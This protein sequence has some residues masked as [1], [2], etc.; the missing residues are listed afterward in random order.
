MSAEADP[1]ALFRQE[2]SELVASIEVGLL[3]LEKR[4]GD[5][6]LIASVFRDLH[7]VKGSGAMFGFTEV[8]AFVHEFETAFDRLRRGEAAV[9][10]DVIAVSLKACDHIRGLLADPAT[11]PAGKPILDA[12][13][14]AMD[15]AAASGAG[16][17]VQVRLPADAI[18]L[19]HHPRRLL[20]ELA[21][22]GKTRIA[23]LPEAIPPLD[24]LDP[25]DCLTGW[26]VEIEGNVDPADVEA[27][28][29]FLAD[30]IDLEITP[31]GDP[32]PSMAEAPREATPA[33]TAAP[34]QGSGPDTMRVATERL[35][36]LMDRVGE[37]VIA[38]AR[39]HSIAQ[40]AGDSVLL[41]VA[42]DI[43]RL[44]EGLRDA[45]M[46]MRMVPIGSI[47]G[48]FRRL[49]RDLSTQL[50][51]PI[52][53]ETSGEDTELD[54]TVIELLADPLVHIIRNAAD[55]GLESPQERQAVCKPETGTIEL[56]A[57]YS[58]AEVLIRVRDDGRGLDP[59]KIRRRAI[60]R[61]LTTEDAQLSEAELFRLVLE[62]GFSTAERVTDLSGRGVGMDVVRRTV[63]D[64]RGQ[65]EIASEPGH[66][67]TI[68]LRLPLTLAIIDG[69]LIEI[70]GEYYSIP[71]AAVEECVELPAPHAAASGA[72]SF[73]NI[74]GSLVPFVR[75]RDL[76]AVTAPPS[77][78][79]KVVVVTS[80]GSRIGLVVDRI[81]ANNQTVIKQ[82][83]R[84]HAA[85]KGFSGAT[86]LG[87]GTVALILDV[88][89]LVALG[90]TIEDRS[91][92]LERAA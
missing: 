30:L 78:F 9:N 86:I 64:L 1:S 77:D 80:G 54:K 89:Q 19:G 29:V 27:V 73:L 76:F 88:P 17:V 39:L 15:S 48:R 28:F 70:G 22:L 36:E 18:R 24:D 82:L 40:T 90:R 5:S 11:A 32:A 10:A 41:V 85:L 72:S 3:D 61:G 75:L 14:G 45:T 67:S 12:L 57:E 50:G 52:R 38:E 65:I 47:T 16:L 33:R 74:R 68:T 21:A 25:T 31:L 35:D 20:D 66:G 4:E 7:T 46:S 53:F 87:D 81:V 55:H 56:D 60:D 26:R 69:L 79:Q 83:S 58:G 42:E 43:Q 84:L 92:R 49:V 6:E 91:A 8:A 71:L 2:A 37:L 23:A 13:A 34:A 63:E 59:A 44:A 51:R 62:P